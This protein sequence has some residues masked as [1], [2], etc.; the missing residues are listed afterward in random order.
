[1]ALLDLDRSAIILNTEF[2]VRYDSNILARRNGGEDTI[3]NFAPSLQFRRA[4]GRG[5]MNFTARGDFVAYA[6][7]SGRNHND[8]NLSAAIT[9]PVSP[10]SPFSGA[11]NASYG[12]STNPSE[13]VG[14]LV[15][16]SA[17]NLGVNGNYAFSERLSGV[18]GAG[19][20]SNKNNGFGDNETYRANV[21]LSFQQFLFRRLPLTLSYAYSRSQSTNDPTAARRLNTESQSFNAGTSG[22]LSAKIDGSVSVGYRSTSDKGTAISSGNGGNGLVTSVGLHWAYDELT[23]ISLGVSKSLAVTPNNNSTDSTSVSLSMTRKLS[24]QLSANLG[25]SQSW[26]NYR[27]LSREDRLLAMNAGV[28]YLIRRNWTAGVSYQFSSNH[29]DSTFNTFDRHLIAATVSG[30][31]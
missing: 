1:M 17:F 11:F 8:Y 31:F 27:G 13:S 15:T 9:A 10:D 3:F 5:T 18:A 20:G 21:G 4:G 30:R 25:A 19:Y 26:N 22:Q 6:S 12:R 7:E 23:K 24:E 28:S 16:T 14:D 29:S 2:G